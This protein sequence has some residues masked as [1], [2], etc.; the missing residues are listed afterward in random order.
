MLHPAFE[1]DL[2]SLF[3][4]FGYTESFTSE[5]TQR[6]IKSYIYRNQFNVLVLDWGNYSGNSYLD[7]VSKIGNV[8]AISYLKKEEFLQSLK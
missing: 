5:S 6:V 2:D 8:C 3:Y 4:C 1:K 7:A